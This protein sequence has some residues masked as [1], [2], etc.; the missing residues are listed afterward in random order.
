MDKPQ[1]KFKIGDTVRI[2][3]LPYSELYKQSHGWNSNMNDYI[4]K[5]LTIASAK[6]NR[7]T[8]QNINDRDKYVWLYT[9]REN[10][11]VYEEYVLTSS[12]SGIENNQ[13][14]WI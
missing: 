11:W 2:K 1:A 13:L 8:N 4:G 14:V 3:N 6:Y 7:N 9:L 10:S 12:S 5:T